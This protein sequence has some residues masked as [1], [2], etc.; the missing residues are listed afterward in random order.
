[1]RRRS[2]LASLYSLLILFADFQCHWLYPLPSNPNSRDS[3]YRSL[4]SKCDNQG[5]V[6]AAPRVGYIDSSATF[7]TP[8]RVALE[9][10]SPAFWVDILDSGQRVQDDVGSEF[11]IIVHNSSGADTEVCLCLFSAV[12]LFLLVISSP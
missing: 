11:S 5:L 1:M 2:F 8:V 10:E 12:S 3:T 6:I 7:G 9:P 4:Q